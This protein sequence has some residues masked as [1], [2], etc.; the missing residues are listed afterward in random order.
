MA[1]R[2]PV[3]V[4]PP[5]PLGALCNLSYVQTVTWPI[6]MARCQLCQPPKNHIH[7]LSNRTGQKWQRRKQLYD[8]L[9]SE[10]NLQERGDARLNMAAA[11]VAVQ[12]HAERQK[13]ERQ[14]R[15]S[16]MD[17]QQRQP[18]LTPRPRPRR[19]M[20]LKED[21]LLLHDVRERLGEHQRMMG[22][23]KNVVFFCAYILCFL[24]VIAQQ[25]AP[26]CKALRPDPPPRRHQQ[27]GPSTRC[28][29]PD[30]AFFFST[31]TPLHDL[32]FRPGFNHKTTASTIRPPL[33]TALCPHSHFQEM[34]SAHLFNGAVRS[35][36]LLLLDQTHRHAQAHRHTDR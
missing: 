34:R 13:Y 7:F 33:H 14:R 32:S 27:A 12:Q 4:G 6:V 8:D 20:A 35:K 25:V 10:R 3:T 9:T 28:T 11:V 31:I 18:Q 5:W 24:S 17:A 36:L 2:S 19:R 15:A 21:F 29:L 30:N 1:P 16:I 26:S 22:Q 23:Y